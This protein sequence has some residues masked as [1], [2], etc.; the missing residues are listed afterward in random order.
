MY[1]LSSGGSFKP[2]YPQKAL[3]LGELEDDNRSLAHKEEE[4]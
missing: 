4:M 1:H 2:Q 3:L